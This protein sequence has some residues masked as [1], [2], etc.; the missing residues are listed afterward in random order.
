M[1][2]TIPETKRFLALLA[3]G[4]G[5]WTLLPVK[6]Q[7]SA[8]ESSAASGSSETSAAIS[9]ASPAALEDTSEKDKWKAEINRQAV[10]VFGKNAELK[11][12]ES[13]EAVVVIGG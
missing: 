10:V 11:T 13:A 8:I 7:E 9:N 5:L 1:K 3:I 6:A 4:F 12:N 2:K